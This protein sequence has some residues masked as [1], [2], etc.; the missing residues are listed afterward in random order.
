VP[1]ADSN[2]V[3]IRI[4]EE[5]TW[6]TTPVSGN[7]RELRLTS[8]SFAPTKDTVVS[9]EIRADRMVSA[10]TEVAAS[11]GGDIN[12]E[13]SSGA[14]DELLAAFLMG[15]WTRPMELDFWSGVSVTITAVN[16]VKVTGIDKRQQ[17]RLLRDFD[18]GR[19]RL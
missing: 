5:G 2:R 12:Y 3:G 4:L 13:F 10:L 14:H 19:Q 6:G 9:D 11:S 8:S 16:V 17:Q 7:T 1:F 15:A 18:G